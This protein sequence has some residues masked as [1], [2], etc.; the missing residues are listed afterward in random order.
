MAGLRLC[1][2]LAIGLI[3]AV[4]TAGCGL[5]PAEPTM[6]DG[7]SIGG[8]AECGTCDERPDDASCVHC[9]SVAAIARGEIE[10]TWPGHP[11]IVNLTFHIEGRYPGPGGE[12]ILRTKSGTLYVAVATFADGTRHAVGVHCGVGDCIAVP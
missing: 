6:L 1:P 5:A 9:S 7:L 8:A 3:V 12:M 10:A 2:I 4:F 11:P